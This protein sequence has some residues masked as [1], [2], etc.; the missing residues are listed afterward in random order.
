[1]NRLLLPVSAL[2]LL[3]CTAPAVAA[4]VAS[5]YPL[6]VP[7]TVSGSGP[8]YRLELP[9]E[10]QLAAAHDDL[11]DLRVF[12]QAGEALPYALR[13]RAGERSSAQRE[14]VARV[15]P[16]YGAGNAEAQSGLRILR[17][18]G[19]TVVELSDAPSA[20]PGEKRRGWLLDVGAA[21]FPLQR[22]QLQWSAPSDGFQ[23]FSIEASDD[24]QHWRRWQDGQVAR[25]SFNGE[26]MDVSDVRLDGERARYLRL[27][28]RDGEE[29]VQVS[30][31]RVSG[32]VDSQAAAPLSW[33]A[34]L[35]GRRDADGSY[36]WTL[37]Q[38]LSVER[39]RFDL[40]AAQAPTIAPVILQS[41]EPSVPVPG[42]PAAALAWQAAARGLLYR[43]TIDGH[44]ALRDE[45]AVNGARLHELRLLTDSRGTGLGTT[46]P[47]LS[48]AAA[49]QELVFLARGDGPYRLALGKAAAE[50]AALPLSVLI[51]GYT[52]S[53]P[54]TLGSATLAGTFQRLPSVAVEAAPVA[55]F[56]WRRAGLWGVLLAGVAL[57]GGMAWS[58]A[59]PRKPNV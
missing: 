46:A 37:P 9:L 28:W 59:R 30:A 23:P 54:P 43:V 45:L 33:S 36:R 58:L 5:D 56:D 53:A 29:A 1:M 55:G 11:R 16:L 40:A 38:A 19:D 57:L 10:A 12:N 17:K 2:A 39:V 41:A 7:L 21:D 26:R 6:Q 24:L 49:G 14:S 4:D 52:D 48:I 22:L 13:L 32:Q 35:E 25:L 44:E 31:A 47:H 8:W 18:G 50:D 42:K 34:P 27:L 51:P 20:A 15:F 3:A